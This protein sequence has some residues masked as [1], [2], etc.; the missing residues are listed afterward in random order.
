MRS[1]QGICLTLPLVDIRVEYYYILYTEE[2][3]GAIMNETHFDAV[4]VGSGF[5]G[6]VMAYR[7]AQAKLRVCVLERG[8]AYPPNSFPRSPYRMKSNFWDPS[9]G[10]HGMFNIWSFQGIDAVVSSGLGGGS[11][12]YANVMLRK[13]EKTFVK[14]D[15]S[16]GGYEYWPVTR[17]DLERH[18]DTVERMQNAQVYP[19]DQSPYNQTR[20]TIALQEAAEKLHMDWSL[21]KLAVTFHN[22][23]EP[24]VPGELIRE[25]YPNIHKRTRVTCRLCGECDLGCNYGSKNTLD[26][27]YLSAANRLGA[28]IR[29][30]CEVRSF[31]PREGGG[32]AIHYVEHD[33]SR[34]GQKLE[35]HNPTMLPLQTITADRL[36]LSAGTF[37]TTFLLLKNRSA[38]PSLSS[39]LGTHFSSNGDLVN[40]AAKCSDQSNGQ[41]VP[42]L[43]ESSYGP[44]ITSAITFPDALDGGEGRGFYIQDGG[45]PDSID[46][47]LQV[48]NSP[49]NTDEAIHVALRRI[50]EWLY[51]DEETD[52]SGTVSELFG[53]S[54]LSSSLFVMLGMGRDIPNGRMSLHDGLLQLDWIKKKSGPYF[55]MVREKMREITQTLG[56]EYIDDPLWYFNR[57]I[58]AHPLGGCPMG[59]NSNEGVVDSYGRVFNYPGLYI[60]DGSVMPGPVGANPSLTIAALAERFA[61]HII[62]DQGGKSA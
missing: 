41:R 19:L 15:L 57:V 3:L 38:F 6:S 9:A 7:L 4:V 48:L 50:K 30:S 23:G 61:E 22:E 32:Y 55:D 2:K 62:E 1:S 59:R 40:F 45:Y 10:L 49:S 58:S 43:I 46:W 34:E 20:K 35:T 26:Y 8:K 47:M 42:R 54:E 56:G 24:P 36:I 17:A 16:N 13:D 11:L 25:E 29:T 12:I 31:E 28:L 52:V 18:Y 5:G 27:T 53:T 39:A 60:A 37:G 44:V 21:L 33:L 14:E 51:R